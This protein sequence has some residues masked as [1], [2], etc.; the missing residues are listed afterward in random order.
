MRSGYIFVSPGY[1]VW[2]VM[3][4]ATEKFVGGD[5]KTLEDAAK[6]VLEH[7]MDRSLDKHRADGESSA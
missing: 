2:K 4:V 1:G 7:P 5:F 3:D 6:Y